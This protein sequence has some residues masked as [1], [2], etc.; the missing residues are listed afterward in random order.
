MSQNVEAENHILHDAFDE[1]DTQERSQKHDFP[2]TSYRFSD[3]TTPNVT[4]V[5]KHEPKN[6]LF[7]FSLLALIGIIFPFFAFCCDFLMDGPLTKAKDSLNLIFSL[8]W[9]LCFGIFA[10]L[11]TLKIAPKAA[12]SGVPEIKAI[13]GGALIPQFLSKRIFF[14]KSV[15]LLAATAAGLFVGREGPFIHLAACMANQL[16]STPFYKKYGKNFNERTAILTSAVAAGVTCTFGS[17]IGGLLFSIEITMSVFLVSALWRGFFTCT[18][19]YI[20]IKA[21][22]QLGVMEILIFSKQIPSVFSWSL[23]FF[24]IEGLLC[25]LISVIFVKSVGFLI[26]HSNSLRRTRRSWIVRIVL[27]CTVVLILNILTYYWPT[28]GVSDRAAIH[29]FT[30]NKEDEIPT[31]LLFGYSSLKIFFTCLTFALPVPAG[32]FGPIFAAG[33]AFGRLFGSALSWSGVL[34]VAP[35]AVAGAASLAGGVTRTLSVSV[36]VFE[37]TGDLSLMLPVL[38]SVVSSYAVVSLLSQSVYDEVLQVKMLPFIPRITKEQGMLKASDVMMKVDSFA[39]SLGSPTLLELLICRILSPV[40]FIV[41]VDEYATMKFIGICKASVIDEYLCEVFDSSV[42]I[43]ILDS[44][45][46]IL[47]DGNVVVRKP[48]CKISPSQWLAQV[49]VLEDPEANVFDKL[50]SVLSDLVEHVAIESW[51]TKSCDPSKLKIDRSPL[52]IDEYMSLPRILSIISFL[53]ISHLQ[54]LDDNHRLMGLV[55]KEM[56]AFSVANASDERIFS[57]SLPQ[58]PVST[59]KQ[60]LLEKF[61]DAREV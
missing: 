5:F 30:S 9:S 6:V 1:T 32:V 37:L 35:Y 46:N 15:G 36:I 44:Q 43:G 41:V 54:V 57:C 26:S 10:L 53:S 22:H 16:L 18:L 56:I 38:C 20:T 40:P 3:D 4:E 49:S 2:V 31:K 33:A 61:S 23:I 17:P 8:M 52:T 28:L 59:L 50:N 29:M 27:L 12:G 51:I 7:V 34:D 60:S 45:E 19:S 58:I 47:E 39:L 24:V 42:N 14:V 25:G 55:T 48:V 21:M 13:L 11:L